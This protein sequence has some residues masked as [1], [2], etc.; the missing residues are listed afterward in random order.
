MIFLDIIDTVFLN[1]CHYQVTLSIN[2]VR[3]NGPPVCPK[4]WLPYTPDSVE[5]LLRDANGLCY[6]NKQRLCGSLKEI[7]Q[8]I[9]QHMEAIL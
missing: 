7:S 5:K 4:V 9:R 6:K 8:Q 2:R 1:W 3:T